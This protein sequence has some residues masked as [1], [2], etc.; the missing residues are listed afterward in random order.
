V[1]ILKYDICISLRVIKKKKTIIIIIINERHA[2]NFANAWKKVTELGLRKGASLSKSMS[3]GRMSFEEDN[4]KLEGCLKFLE[5]GGDFE[6]CVAA[7]FTSE[8]GG[9][10]VAMFRNE[11]GVD[12]KV[13]PEMGQLTAG[14]PTELKVIY[15]GGSAK[16]TRL[17]I[18]T[19]QEDFQFIISFEESEA[20]S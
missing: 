5:G 4:S 11:D 18:E 3:S 8:Y 7:K 14:E 19:E 9:D 13:V 15:K 10:F 16:N 12:I 17:L 6:Q 20:S 1:L 2:L